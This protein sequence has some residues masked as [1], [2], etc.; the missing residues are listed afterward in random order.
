MAIK[1]MFCLRRNPDLTREEFQSYWLENHAPIVK[2]WAAETG[3]T[4]YVQC[5]VV[6][7]RLSEPFARMRGTAEPYDGVMEGWWESEEQALAVIAVHGK[8]VG[9]IFLEDER[10][11]IDLERSSLFFVEEHEIFGPT[12]NTR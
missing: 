7:N 12:E 2:R 9:R 10:R 6:D 3:M 8:K 4:R 1:L 11:F 5:H